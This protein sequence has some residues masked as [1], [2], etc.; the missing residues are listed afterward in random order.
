[1][2]LEMAT[3][4]I[5]ELVGIWFAAIATFA[6]TLVALFLPKLYRPRLSVSCNKDG[7]GS[8]SYMFDDTPGSSPIRELWIKV[9]VKN[10]SGLNAEDVQLRLIMTHNRT[11]PGRQGYKLFSSWWLKVSALNTVSISIPP[12]Y[13][14]YYDLCYLVAHRDSRSI[15]VHLPAVRPP[16]GDWHSEKEN[17]ESDRYRMLQ[18]RCEYD[19]VFAV[20]GKNTHAGYFQISVSYDGPDSLQS[21][22][23]NEAALRHAIKVGP[24]KRVSTQVELDELADT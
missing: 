10:K 12:K 8:S 24:P 14:Q 4:K 9:G 23:L 17:I 13:T 19:I 7:I 2:G 11:M 18:P 6:A 16:M 5:I 1:M 22:D 20:S 15:S 3:D 21:D